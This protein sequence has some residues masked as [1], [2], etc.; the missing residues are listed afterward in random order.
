MNHWIIW[1]LAPFAGWILLNGIDDLFID[2]V[3]CWR[4]LRI[5]LLFDNFHW[6][7]ATD[8]DR[9]RSRPIAVFVP[10]WHEHQ[11]IATMLEHNLSAVRYD[12]YDFFCRM[13][14]VY[15]S[16]LREE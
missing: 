7:S 11:V 10:L 13:P 12:A 5:F 2:L 1:A 8:L 14:V 15:H 16:S 3:F 9:A 4:A 6:P